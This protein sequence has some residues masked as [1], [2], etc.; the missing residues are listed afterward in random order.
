MKLPKDNRRKP[1]LYD[2]VVGR[3]AITSDALDLFAGDKY[4][5]PAVEG[6][7]TSHY[8]LEEATIR[9]Q[10]VF[11]Q[12]TRA[13]NPCT[14]NI[15]AP[16]VQYKTKLDLLNKVTS[17]HIQ[18]SEVGPNRHTKWLS[19]HREKTNREQLIKDPFR[20]WET[21]TVSWETSRC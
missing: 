20:I 19:G 17:L 6:L 11:E 16:T 2:E 3:R 12:L 9:V 18:P 14:S 10:E 5:E 8:V 7:A 1:F 21:Y 15:D 4:F 13:L